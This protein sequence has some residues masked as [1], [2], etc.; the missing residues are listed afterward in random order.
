MEFRILG[1]LEVH[2]ECGALALGGAKPRA[3]L[4]VLLLHANESVSAERLALALW[5]EDA[6]PSAIKRIQVHVSRLRKALGRP[7][8]LTTTPAGYRLRVLPGELDAELFARLLQ[9][10]HRALADGDAGHAAAVLREAL[11]L[12]RG[13]PLA[14]LAFEPFAQ[15]AIARLEEQRLAALEGRVEADLRQHQHAALV[16]ELRQLVSA[17]PARERLVGQ[18]MLALYRCGRQGDALDVYARARAFLSG[19]LGLEPGPALKGLQRAIL[20]QAAS[21]EL[22]T[23]AAG[24][25]VSSQGD[26]E[27][28]F[29]VPSVLVPGPDD[30]FVGRT[31]DLETLADVYALAA[32]GSRRLVLL[33]GEP[34]IGK[35]R[36][37]AEFALRAHEE[38]AIV[39]YGRC[40]EEGLLAQQPFVEALRHYVSACPVQELAG[41]LQTLS[42]ELRRIVPELAERIPD[43]AEPLAGDPE[44]ARSRLF[45]AVSSLLCEAAQSTPVVLVLDD[46][47]WAD[48]ATLLLLKYLA[49]YPR[50]ARL[51]VLGTYRETELDA[52][53][54]LSATLAQLGRE[55]LLERHALTPLDEGAVSQLVGVH[56]GDEASPELR[57]L[58]YEGTEGNAFF[59]VEVL[60]HLAESGALGVA[61]AELGPATGRLS[62]PEGVKEV[63]GQRIAR[64]GRETNRLLTMASV[65]GGEFELELLLR[66]SEL[67]ED[68]LVD[69]L[70]SAVRAR[71]VEEVAGAAGRFRFSHAL[72]R[73]T[74]Y[75]GLSATRCAM[76][77]RRAGAALE[78]AHGGRL[79]PYLAELAHHFAQAGSSGDL[80]KAI[81]YGSRAGDHAI[82][83]LA[84]E[85][86]A[87]HFRRAVELVDAA[88]PARL[89]RQRCD[90]VIAQG[91][92]ERQA[93]D[94]AYRQTLLDGSGLALELRD[95]ERLARAALAN[96]RGV[97]SS[98]QG[99][100]RERVAVLHAALD[101][102]D[103]T[104]SPTRAALL[105]LLALELLTDS[106][107]RL[108]D[109]LNDEALAMARRVGDQ[110]TLALVLTQRSVAQW[111]PTQTP[112]ERRANL[113]EAGELADRLQDPLLAGHVAYLG[114]HAAMNAG[115][116]QEADQLL[117]RLTAVAEQLAQPFMLWC[118]GLA[119]A[120]RCSISG[121]GEEAERLAFA[122]L[123]IGRRGGQPDSNLWFLG[124]LL[125]ARFLQGA[126]HR[127]DPHLPDLIRT[128]GASLPTSPEITPSQAM[129]LLVGA[130]AS[131]VL[132]EVGRLDDARRH[133][134]FVMSNGLDE[135][136]P[137][138]LA[139][140]IPVYA[141]VACARLG[142]TRRAAR[143]HAIL[144]P[145]SDRL[146]STGA[147]WFGVTSHYLGLLA[148][149]LDRP[150][151]ADARFAA[152]EQTYASLDAKPWLARL[153][154]D[155]AALLARRRGNDHRHAEQFPERA[156]VHRRLR[157]R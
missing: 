146:V 56:V 46:L 92:A 122:A 69:G 121:S 99:V 124:Q 42:G 15:A 61:G 41:R 55:R 148:A 16:G 74:L 93:G 67:D 4:A 34:G 77:H 70:D 31:A 105:A 11:Q 142:D 23:P 129:P 7:K 35:T 10:G 49:R 118:D 28:P 81:E 155:R 149:T 44:G 64:L 134:E 101:A 126:L 39:L 65:L 57:R 133:F 14:D 52:D 143:L 18:L 104:D 96:N 20:E 144:E 32:G 62:V 21:L 30:L 40:D 112:A 157:E 98:G 29:P 78:Q 110:R 48:Q 113:R 152:A 2:G 12:S 37:A 59:V 76:L 13:P 54:L 140:T 138:Y 22:Q 97:F 71:V 88:D 66:L 36:L 123:E 128:P 82:S 84:Y 139:L 145:H 132:C 58:V 111:T 136:P 109:K 119:R 95:P 131:A 80:D 156:A 151:E 108:R 137:D 89:Q 38:G 72:I 117:T 125:A 85:Q 106:D 73:E 87:A 19:E 45:E 154:N 8:I 3:L 83:Q 127:R 53:H 79:E 115:D 130:A 86:A 47:H 103:I 25:V 6:P 51:M 60:R 24:G 63:I 147:S 33:S 135:L 120:K 17:N 153:R 114:A 150:D 141:S 5:G 9:D 116:L 50:Q 102:Y 43:L 26:A 90:L 100:D 1:P 75:G 91:E 107:C 94:P 27:Q 68:Q